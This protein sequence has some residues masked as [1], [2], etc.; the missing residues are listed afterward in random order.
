[1]PYNEITCK[2]MPSNDIWF[3]WATTCYS[4]AG[5]TD[6]KIISDRY[7]EYFGNIARQKLRQAD[8]RNNHALF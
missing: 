8:I 7:Q 5:A 4:L 3:R 6:Y 1:M 2:T